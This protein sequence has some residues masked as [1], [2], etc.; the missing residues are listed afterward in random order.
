SLKLLVVP[1]VFVSLV[2]GT[3]SFEDIKKLGKIGS[4]TFT[5]YLA[6]TAL[7]ITLALVVGL[8]VSPGQGFELAAPPTY[9]GAKESPPLVEVIA[10]IFP[11]NPIQ[12]MAQGE[13][14]QIIVFA[15]LFG[16]GLSLSGS[17]GRRVLAIF[18]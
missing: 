15:L 11:S 7:A 17:S 5:F 2:A 12:S 9:Q 16:I 13:M 8:I 1:M 18:N 3:G 6:T 14:L 4:R 10:N